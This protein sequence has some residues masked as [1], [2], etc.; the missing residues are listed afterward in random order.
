[1]MILL[2]ML[3]LVA[4]VTMLVLPSCELRMPARG[5]CLGAAERPRWVGYV[6]RRGAAAS[7]E[8]F[9]CTRL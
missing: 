2:R 6:G 8:R 7:C 3:L 1:M 9:G 4:V 5:C